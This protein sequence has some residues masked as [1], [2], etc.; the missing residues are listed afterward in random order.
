MNFASEGK[1]GETIL[2]VMGEDM[3]KGFSKKNQRG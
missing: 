2:V 1:K 3:K